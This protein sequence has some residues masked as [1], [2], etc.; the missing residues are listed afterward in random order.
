MGSVWVAEHEGLGCEVAV[1]FLTDEYA[2]DES[3]RGRF[4]QEAAASSRVKSVHVVKVYDFGV[5]DS[6]VPYLVMELLE[7]TDLRH[8]LEER[9]KL[10]PEEV[11]TIL[12]Q[13]C[14]AL[15]RANEADVVHRD[16]KPEN[17]F[18]TIE[19]GEWFVKLLDFGVAKTAKPLVRGVKSTLANETL[20]TPFYMSPELFRSAKST[21]WR[22]DAWAVGVIAYEALTGV[23]P[24]DADT[25]NALAIAVDECKPEPPSRRN[26]TLPAAFDAWFAKACARDPA[27]R[28][29]SWRE[30]IEGLRAAFPGAAA[31][32]PVQAISAS[33]KR[34]I[35]PRD[36]EEIALQE[37]AF[38][39]SG[40][41]RASRSRVAY[42]VGLGVIVA[43]ASVVAVIKARTSAAPA[44]SK[45]APAASTSAV[46]TPSAI[47]S[48]APPVSASAVASVSL[49]KLVPRARASTTIAPSASV[50]KPANK[51]DLDIY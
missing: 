19:A 2:K 4:A 43:C 46:T 16:V 25:V 28:F 6:G 42:G 20:G 36:A 37:T 12:V 3:W 39:T 22:C 5:T 31:S 34:V 30:L 8:L 41:R 14:R 47:V 29:A 44:E 18:L 24:F 26:P 48:A 38:A 35:T 33:G 10:P 45:A 17:V 27:A 23:R 13:L 49:P 11:I 9:H 40:A 1:K 7:G 15:E 21:D 50:A 32:L 51:D